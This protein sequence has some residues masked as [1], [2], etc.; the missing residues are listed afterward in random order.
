M[1]RSRT[2]YSDAA[3][4][5]L[6]RVFSSAVIDPVPLR[7]KNHASTFTRLGG[8]TFSEFV[9]RF[10]VSTLT[11]QETRPSSPGC[12]YMN[13]IPAAAAAERSVGREFT[14]NAANSS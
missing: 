1:G 7:G 2:R 4:F 9:R 11:S 3:N 5:V 12:I 10:I 6:G 13:T 8:E 14:S